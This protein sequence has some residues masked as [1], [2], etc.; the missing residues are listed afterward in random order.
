MKYG[1]LKRHFNE[2]MEVTE[3]FHRNP[4]AFQGGLDV[5]ERS[6]LFQKDYPNSKILINYFFKFLRNQ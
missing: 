2:I 4:G 6:E 3:A 1:D 5:Q